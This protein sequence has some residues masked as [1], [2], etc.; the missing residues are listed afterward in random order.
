MEKNTKAII[1][2]TL[3][4]ALASVGSFAIFSQY[5][6]KTLKQVQEVKGL[7]NDNS[8][9]FALPEGA[10]KIGSNRSTESTQTTF[11]TSKKKDNV[12]E[13][14]KNI[15]STNNWKLESQ[16]VNENYIVTKYEKDNKL[17]VVSTF[18]TQDDNETL[19]NLELKDL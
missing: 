7:Q 1:I 12:Q 13:F 2:T 17:F 10:T 3:L 4:L 16:N 6:P 14:Y 15:Y 18:D 9:D 5:K 8:T 19:V 11:H